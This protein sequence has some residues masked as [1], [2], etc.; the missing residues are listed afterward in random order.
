LGR[1]AKMSE[2]KAAVLFLVS[3]ASSYMTGT[4]VIIDGGRSCW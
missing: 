4:N 3:E 1:M 2:Y